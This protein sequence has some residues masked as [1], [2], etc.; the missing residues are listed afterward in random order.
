MGDITWEIQ[1]SS[2]HSTVSPAFHS[3]WPRLYGSL[4]H[5]GGATQRGAR[6][7]SRRRCWSMAVTSTATGRVHRCIIRDR[8]GQEKG[9]TFKNKGNKSSKHQCWINPMFFM[10]DLWL[11]TSGSIKTSMP[12]GMFSWINQGT[13]RCS[14]AGSYDGQAWKLWWP[15]QPGPHTMVK[16]FEW[17]SFKD[18]PWAIE[19]QFSFIE[20]SFKGALP[21][22]SVIIFGQGCTNKARPKHCGRKPA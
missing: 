12:C 17:L 8:F 13:G 21:K 11:K 10:D 15:Q 16:G 9:V 2:Q 20:M 18:L 3:W 4:E 5:P 7:V 6:E 1:M 19:D 22:V 14:A